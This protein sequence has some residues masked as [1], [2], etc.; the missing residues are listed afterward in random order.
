MAPSGA[1]DVSSG[2]TTNA[3][4]LK[5]EKDSPN[6]KGLF[7]SAFFAG[8]YPGGGDGERKVKFL[9]FLHQLGD[10]KSVVKWN[11]AVVRGQTFIQLPD[12]PLHECS[13]DS[14]VELLD[15]AEE[16]SSKAIVFF[17]KERKD[18]RQLIRTF[19]YI[20]FDILPPM[21]NW[22]PASQECFFM[23]YELG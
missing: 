4:L 6:L 15:V 21:C 13:R 7:A 19:K 18:A 10:K 8:Q 2:I 3:L 11:T 23:S 22:I 5:A 14:L 20:G 9:T 17:S 12:D 1:P 16:F